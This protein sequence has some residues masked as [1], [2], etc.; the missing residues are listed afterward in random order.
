[1]RIAQREQEAYSLEF[2]LAEVNCRYVS[3]EF[4]HLQICPLVPHFRPLAAI[5]TDVYIF[6]AFKYGSSEFSVFPVFPDL[7]ERLLFQVAEFVLRVLVKATG[8]HESVP[9]NNRIMPE[10]PAVIG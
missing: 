3:F 5:G 2:G 1:M 8:C 4:F 6:S 9:G 10:S 7:P